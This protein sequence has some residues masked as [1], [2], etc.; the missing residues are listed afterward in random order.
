MNVTLETFGAIQGERLSKALLE[1]K[2]P[3]NRKWKGKAVCLPKKGLKKI[4][5]LG[6]MSLTLFS[7]DHQELTN[8]TPRWESECKKAGL[9]PGVGA[10]PSKLKGIESF[11]EIDI[12]Q[13]AVSP[14]K[15]DPGEANGSSIAVLAQ[16]SGK[17]ALLTGDAHADRIADSIRAFK[18]TA[19]RLKLH[20]L[21]VAHHASEHNT[22]QELVELLE[23]ERFLVSTNGS[24]FKHP[25]PTAIARLM[26]YGGKGATFFFNYRTKYTEVWDSA[27]WK[28]KYGYRTVYSDKNHN[29]SLTVSL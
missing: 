16:Y 12:E 3:W 25:T 23:C 28:A 2:L 17:K 26:K 8:F 29:G 11:G 20:A 18:R 13:L 5:L 4:T 1:G 9:I 7:P 15:A 6:G 19:K 27:V 24:Y 10:K 21:K 14:F 22:S